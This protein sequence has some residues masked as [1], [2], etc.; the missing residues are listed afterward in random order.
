VVRRADLRLVR[1]PAA[2]RPVGTRQSASAWIGRRLA[3]PVARDEPLTGR[4][5]VGRDL[6]AGLSG[7]QVAVSVP[8]IDRHVAEL[9]QPGERVELLATLRAE[10]T[11]NS[12]GP[13]RPDAG[14]A[15]SGEAAR[16][17]AS[18]FTVV[19]HALVLAVFADADEDAAE[20]VLAVARPI[21]LSIARHRPNSLFT[22]VAAPP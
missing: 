6:T 19:R 7:D 1:W 9:A 14:A 8:V 21:A 11:D 22:V 3:G 12:A 4:R 18:L 16:E 5:V 13:R 2:L 20:V 10:E 17:S 15:G